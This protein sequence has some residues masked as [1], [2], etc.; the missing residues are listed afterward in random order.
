MGRK[1]V[2]GV[3]EPPASPT[4]AAISGKSPTAWIRGGRRETRGSAQMGLSVDCIIAGG[5]PEEEPE[6]DDAVRAWKVESR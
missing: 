6:E 2:H 3:S 5:P 4:R 1:T